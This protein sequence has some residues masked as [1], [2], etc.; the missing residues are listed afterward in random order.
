[1]MALKQYEASSLLGKPNSPTPTRD[2]LVPSKE[3]I[4][5]VSDMKYPVHSDSTVIRESM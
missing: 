4:F 2:A 1:M 5:D 3:N